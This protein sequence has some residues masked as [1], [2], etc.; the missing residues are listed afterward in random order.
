MAANRYIIITVVY[1]C[2]TRCERSLERI[3]PELSNAGLTIVGDRA[4]LSPPSRTWAGVVDGCTLA[5]FARAWRLHGAD[6]LWVPDERAVVRRAWTLD[7]MNSEVDGESPIVY[8]HVEVRG[9][10][11]GD[12]ARKQAA[13]RVGRADAGLARYPPRRDALVA[14]EPVS[15]SAQ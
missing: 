15:G 6:E 4:D 8:V 10:S 12:G 13:G 7:G 9:T 11:H 5:E 14:C 2:P 3:A 1:D